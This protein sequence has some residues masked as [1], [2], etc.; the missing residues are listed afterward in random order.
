[1]K[2]L[3]PGGVQD[4][5]GPWMACRVSVASWSFR[6]A[7][8]ALKPGGTDEVGRGG[9]SGPGEGDRNPTGN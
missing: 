5:P 2:F 1:M 8:Q 7:G 3:G 6:G 9:M 4:Q